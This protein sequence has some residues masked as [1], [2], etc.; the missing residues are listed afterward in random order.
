MWSFFHNSNSNN[1]K[2]NDKNND[3][4]N[5][6]DNYNDKNNDANKDL[7]LLKNVVT[8]CAKSNHA[9]YTKHDPATWLLLQEAHFR[10]QNKHRR[11][12]DKDRRHSSGTTASDANSNGQRGMQVPFEVQINALTNQRQVYVTRDIPKGYQIWKPHHYHTF[13]SEHSYIEFLQELPH[14]LQCDVLEWTHPSYHDNDV[15]VDITLDE[16]TFI[17]EATLSEQVNIDIDCVALREIKAGEFV[18]MNSTEHFSPDSGVAWLETIRSDAWKRTG[19]GMGRASRSSR[20]N[21][22]D[23]RGREQNKYEY[24]EDHIIIAPTMAVLS[25]LYFVVKLVQ[26]GNNKSMVS[27]SCDYGD[28]YYDTSFYNTKRTKIA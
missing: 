15:F 3:N 6:N 25:A 12:K 8:G 26:R 2:N 10:V 19:L 14:H 17:Q 28:D 11:S 24:A 9:T 4:D 22:H 13:R 7:Q 1:D 20:D 27:S 16:G 23:G 21:A 5:D 18:Y